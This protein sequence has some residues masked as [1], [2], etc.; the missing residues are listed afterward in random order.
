ME[1]AWVYPPDGRLEQRVVSAA[2]NQ[3][4]RAQPADLRQVPLQGALRARRVG[5]ARL[6]YL[7]QFRAR[8]LV[9]ADHGVELLDRVQVFLA[10]GGALGRDHADQAFAGGFDRCLGAGADDADD[11]HVED[12][13]GLV[14]R[15]RGGGVARDH[16]HLD[17]A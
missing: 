2:E 14:E 3:D 13:A 10:V 15:R 8:L 12:L 6:H 1:A 4:V 5:V 9:H 17:V 7:D 16:D 11:G